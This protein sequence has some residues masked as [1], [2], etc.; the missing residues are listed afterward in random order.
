M[1]TVL[2]LTILQFISYFWISVY[3]TVWSGR[4]TT[5]LNLLRCMWWCSH[6]MTLM[7]NRAS[8]GD[9][10]DPSGR[11]FHLVRLTIWHRLFLEFWLVNTWFYAY[12][13]HQRAVTCLNNVRQ[14]IIRRGKKQGFQLSHRQPLCFLLRSLFTS[15]FDEKVNLIFYKIIG[16]ELIVCLLL[17]YVFIIPDLLGTSDI[18]REKDSAKAIRPFYFERNFSHF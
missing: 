10:S 2:F 1:R 17:L 14:L 7:L 16:L 3:I 13:H 9:V 8:F 18:Q 12:W 6:A 11:H 15:C 5:D 4:S